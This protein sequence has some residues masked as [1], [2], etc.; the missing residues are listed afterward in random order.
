VLA[1]AT[2]AFNGPEAFQET[3]RA[4]GILGGAHLVMEAPEVAEILRMDVKG[5]YAAAKTKEIPGGKRIGRL[6]RFSRKVFFDWLNETGVQ[7]K[8][9]PLG[10]L[11]A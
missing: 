1:S 6:L 8:D 3:L 7:G 11:R 9:K 2:L 10:R 4:C 5:V